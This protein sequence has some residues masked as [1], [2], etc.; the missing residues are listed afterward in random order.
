MYYYL[1]G[2]DEENANTVV[3]AKAEH[4]KNVVARKESAVPLAK[5]I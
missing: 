2:F 4:F 5:D 1:L 3:S